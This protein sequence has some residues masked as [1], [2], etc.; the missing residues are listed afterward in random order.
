MFIGEVRGEKVV[1]LVFLLSLFGFF[2]V[3]SPYP[4]VVFVCS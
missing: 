1:S 4:Y 3:P 2:V